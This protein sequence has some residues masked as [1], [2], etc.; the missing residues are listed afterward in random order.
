[1]NA[2]RRFAAV[3]VGCVALA[4]LGSGC[5][6]AE[7]PTEP[8]PNSSTVSISDEAVTAID[9][10][11]TAAAI[12]R[13]RA[14]WRTRLPKPTQVI[15]D[16]ARKYF[17]KMQTNKGSIVI[18]FMSDIAPM[19]VTNFIYLTRL[20]FY[21]GLRFHRVI[22]GFMAQGG[23]PVGDWLGAAGGPGYQFGGEFNPTV[24]HDAAGLLSMA[25]AGEGTDGSQFFFTFVPTP[26]LNGRHTI[27]G[28]VTEGMDTLK[29]LEAA[30]SPTGATSEP[31]LIERV[32][33]D[34]Q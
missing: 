20:G 9:R 18:R 10:Q 1:M 27:F 32:T 5:G 28:K 31:L 13:T 22:T 15:F 26:W 17:A 16:P 24:R 30:G 8:T 12:D 25:N 19:H 14:G 29:R 34:V 4:V 2:T 11:I 23:D 3:A 21:D 33:I 6:G 7:N